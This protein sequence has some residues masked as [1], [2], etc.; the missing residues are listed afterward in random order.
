LL[1]NET[2]SSVSW[3]I[4]RAAASSITNASATCAMGSGASTGTTTCCSRRPSS[5]TMELAVPR[6]VLSTT[7]AE[8]AKGRPMRAASRVSAS[9][10]PSSETSDMALAPSRAPWL[11]RTES[12]VAKSLVAMAWRKAKSAERM[13]A[14]CSSRPWFCAS[15]LRKRRSPCSSCCAIACRAICELARS[16]R[17]APRPWTSTS[18]ATKN[19][20]SRV[21]RL[22][23]RVAMAPGRR[24]KP[25]AILD[26]GSALRETS[27]MGRFGKWLI[28]ASVPA[29]PALCSGGTRRHR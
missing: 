9:T 2:S 1:R 15:A 19:T 26:M 20:T 14:P 12:M 21:P 25:I 6:A 17:M 22:V 7:S 27:S 3:F 5:A 10:C 23:R 18:S 24:E 4:S 29:F 28:V 11:R 8:K 13:A 16:T